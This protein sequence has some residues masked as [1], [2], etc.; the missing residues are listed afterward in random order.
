MAMTIVNNIL[1][2]MPAVGRP[3]RKFLVL[4]FSTILALRG[5][6][7]FR[8]LSRYCD[9]SERT[10][11]RQFRRSFD[12]PDFHQR[13]MTTALHLQAEV[14]S[15]Q[16]ASCIPKSGKQ[17]FGLGHFF[18]GC[19]GRAERGLEISTLAVVDVTHRC[20]FTLAVAQTPPTYATATQQEQEATLVDFYAQQLRVH[21]HRLPA[22]VAYHAVD[23]YFAKKKYLDAVVDLRLHPITK[24][25]GDADCR[26]LFTGPHPKRRGAHRKYDGKVHWQDLSRFEALG[27][28]AEAE[29]VHLYTA[30][31][32]H[33]TLKRKL[34][35]VIL[36]NRKAP[37]KPRYI[38]LASTDLAL[39]GRKLVELYGARFQIEFLFRDSQQFT[40]LNDCQA[41]AEAA[42]DFHFNAAL[43]TLNLVRAA[44][45]NAQSGNALQVFSMASWKQRQF[46]ERLLDFFIEKLALDPTWVKNHPADDELRI[47]GAIAA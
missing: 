29:H 18:N 16:D 8:N 33:V 24:L 38:V 14:I 45:L 35:A 17:T 27:T 4:L 25:R 28:L 34:R 2:Q 10:I 47:Y 3:Q 30:L 37:A 19:A 23:G 31:V 43:A 39:D 41:R 11:A 40:G 42:L 21:Q 26:F 15:A 6:V 13:V 44:D 9:D 1:K 46:N 20:A 7:N 36:I 5:R 12:W 22:W 32:W